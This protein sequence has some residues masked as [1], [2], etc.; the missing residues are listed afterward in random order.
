MH[1]RRENNLE[2][3][4]KAEYCDEH[5]GGIF[6]A[7]KRLCR[8]QASRRRAVEHRVAQGNILFPQD[9]L[10]CISSAQQCLDGILE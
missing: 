3:A 4:S 6:N 10:A 8:E 2:M 7:R 9:F 5:V 1:F